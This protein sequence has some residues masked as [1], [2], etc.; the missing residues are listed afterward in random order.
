MPRKELKRIDLEPARGFSILLV[1][2]FHLLGVLIGQQQLPWN[3]WVRSL[4]FD[5]GLSMIPFIPLTLGWH[6]VAIFFAISGYCI[7]LSWL[8][9]DRKWLSFGVRRSCRLLPTYFLWLLVF[10]LGCWLVPDVIGAETNIFQFVT[11][12]FVVHNWFGETLWGINP[13]F[14][15]IAVEIQLYALLPLLI[16]MVR[17]FGWGKTLLGLML[18]EVLFRA[19]WYLI[20]DGQG[21]THIGGVNVYGITFAYW[22]SWSI[23]AWVAARQYAG[24][25]SAFVYSS[26][27]HCCSSGSR[28][29]VH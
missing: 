12:A 7:Q 25:V 29:L 16:C 1:F 20:L 13:S 4:H 10:S 19:P 6:G 5:L 24:G 22:F 21:F 27:V 2:G 3:G 23:G 26:A 28:M 9:S 17:K 11:H 14:W 15:S 18:L 8:Q